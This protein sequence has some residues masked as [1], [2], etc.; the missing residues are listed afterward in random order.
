[1]ASKIFA[2]VHLNKPVLR[3]VVLQAMLKLDALQRAKQ[4]I[5]DIL[6]KMVIL[7]LVPHLELRP[8]S[9]IRYRV[10]SRN[11]PVRVAPRLHHNTNFSR[12]FNT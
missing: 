2:C 5:N 10:G 4:A 1:M 9:T 11:A 8:K 6:S 3:F 7:S 12:N